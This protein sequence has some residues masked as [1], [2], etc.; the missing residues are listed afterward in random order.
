V[1][2]IWVIMGGSKLGQIYSSYW[3]FAHVSSLCLTSLRE[4]W[5]FSVFKLI[6]ALLVRHFHCCLC[7]VKVFS[8][9]FRVFSGPTGAWLSVSERTFIEALNV[10]FLRRW[11]RRGAERVK[12]SS[13]ARGLDSNHLVPRGRPSN[14]HICRQFMAKI[15]FQSRTD[16]NGN[17]RRSHSLSKQQ[18]VNKPIILCC[19][20]FWDAQTG[21]EKAS[22]KSD[23]YLS[24]RKHKC[25]RAQCWMRDTCSCPNR[26]FEALWWWAGSGCVVPVSSR[27]K[28]PSDCRRSWPFY[29]CAANKCTAAVGDS[30]NIDIKR[31]KHCQQ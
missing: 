5:K 31:E 16:L 14:L 28:R 12:T 25:S 17:R 9:F 20:C 30:V 10:L 1:L 6:E 19:R 15:C 7:S 21:L 4:E 11:R 26:W 8:S 24:I 13:P 3:F 18:T 23:F 27:S 22:T 2:F 29:R